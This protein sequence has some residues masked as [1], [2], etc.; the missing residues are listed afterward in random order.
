MGPKAG[1][2]LHLPASAHTASGFSRVMAPNTRTRSC[3]L[4]RPS[5]G[6]CLHLLLPQFR[7]RGTKAQRHKVFAHGHTADG[8]GS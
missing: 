4:L 3:R 8:G 5:Q 7:D 2:P 1:L 6:P